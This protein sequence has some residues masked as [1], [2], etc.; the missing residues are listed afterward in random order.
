M[1]IYNPL[2]SCLVMLQLCSGRRVYVHTAVDKQH[3]NMFSDAATVY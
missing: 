1:Y 3:L 2:I